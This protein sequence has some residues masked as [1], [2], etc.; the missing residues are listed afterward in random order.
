MQ[1]SYLFSVGFQLFE[2]DSLLQF[3][4][5]G[6]SERQER[7]ALVMKELQKILD[8]V[9]RIN[10]LRSARVTDTQLDVRVA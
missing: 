3:L 6:V 8:V 1:H 7:T 5:S 4:P 9:M 2:S 10:R